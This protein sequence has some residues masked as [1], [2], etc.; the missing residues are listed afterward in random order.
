M[1]TERDFDRI[2]QAWLEESPDE[3][4]AQAIA[5]V[6]QAID[7]TPQVRSSWR[8]LIWRSYAMNRLSIALAAAAVVAVAGTFLLFRAGIPPGVGSSPTPA[9]L[10][11]SS[12]PAASPS[13][14]APA[15]GGPIPSELRGV[16]MGDHRGLVA[17]SAGTAIQFTQN[18]FVLRQS[19]GSAAEFLQSTASATGA[20]QI[21]L[22]SAA[23]SDACAKGDVGTYSWSLTPSGRT[24]T[25]TE[26]QDACPTRAG[27]LDGVWWLMACPTP[28]D[29]CLGVV[30][31]GTYKSQFIGPRLDRGG[32]W[33]PNFGAVTY[34][35][36]DGW[37]NSSDWPES[38]GLVPA[39]EAP[40]AEVDRSRQLG[41]S[42][43]P[44][45]MTQDKPCS[46][47]DD[48]GVGKSVNNLV[49]WLRTVPGLVTTAPTAITIDGRPGQWVDVRLDPAWRKTCP[50]ETK[51]IVTYLNPGT[52][53]SGTERE[54]AILLDLGDGDVVEIMVWARDQAAFDS[55]IAEAM[56]IVESFRFE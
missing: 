21:R 27:G 12:G 42:T 19:A 52:A 26:K 2:A 6:L 54:R 5:A 15:A 7:S 37:A 53:I 24:L 11:S 39:T 20:A 10:T 16:W 55:F 32:A 33:A 22:E 18:S 31:A 4:P 35:V 46:D 9:A 14:S 43:Q 13:G 28:D 17:Q 47:A 40:L 30:D 3:A 48:S 51:P 1:T 45:A 41:I 25:I 34:T 23:A 56:P 36:P 38:F 44:T 8:R 49:A 50:G 29:N